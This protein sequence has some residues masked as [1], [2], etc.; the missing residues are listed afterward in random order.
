V[1]KWL[2][3]LGV[4][5]LGALIGYSYALLSCLFGS[6]GAGMKNVTAEGTVPGQT[7]TGWQ[8]RFV[9]WLFN[10]IDN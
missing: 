10:K 5:M 6:K 3:R 7:G 2:K 9:D 8:D 4:L 1:V